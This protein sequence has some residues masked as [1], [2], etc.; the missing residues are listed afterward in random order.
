MANGQGRSIAI[1]F[2]QKETPTGN[3]SVEPSVK[4]SVEL[5]F[6]LWRLGH[7]GQDTDKGYVP[8]LLDVGIM[9]TAPSKLASVS[10]YLPFPIENKDITDLGPKFAD[11]SLA[12]GIFNDTITATNSP[13]ESV[14]V[15]KRACSTTHCGVLTFSTS[16]SRISESYINIKQDFDGSIITVTQEALD[17]GIRGIAQNDKLYLRLRITIPKNGADTFFNAAVPDDGWFTSSMDVTECLDFRLNQA[18]NLN[19]GISGKMAAANSPTAVPI[20]RLD[21]LLV[22]GVAVDVVVGYSN[23]H[24]CRLLEKD[25]WRYYVDEAHLKKGMVVYHWKKEKNDDNPLVDFNAFVKLRVRLSSWRIIKQYWVIAFLFGGI[26]GVFGNTLYDGAK[27]LLCWR[28]D[29]MCGA[30]ESQPPSSSRASCPEASTAVAAPNPRTGKPFQDG[31]IDG[32][33]VNGSG[34]GPANTGNAGSATGGKQQ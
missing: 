31:N 18:R 6:N 11:A 7:G 33:R 29:K 4:P 8:D 19:S 14:I 28:F 1:W 21:F 20:T 17:S 15:L 12:T 13:S 22:V 32:S 27:W 10:F 9:V 25:I 2:P 3:P 24:K 23:F 5:H 30:I 26:V 16:G 34:S